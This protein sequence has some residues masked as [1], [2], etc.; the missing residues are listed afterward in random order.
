MNHISWFGLRKVDNLP[1]GD[2]IRKIHDKQCLLYA[3]KTKTINN[4]V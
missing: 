2:H 1:L 4:R 3:N